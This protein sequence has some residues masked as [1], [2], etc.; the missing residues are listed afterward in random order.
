MPAPNH[1]QV[2]RGGRPRRRAE[3]VGPSADA[4]TSRRPDLEAAIERH[5]QQSGSTRPGLIIACGALVREINA[6][7]DLNDIALFDVRAIPATYHNRPERI[8]G[9][10]DDLL[11]AAGGHY[12]HVFV[13]YAEC[14]TQG[15]LDAVLKRHGVSRLPGAHCYSVFSGAAHFDA[16]ADR[17]PTAFYLTDFLARHFV[18]LVWRGLGLDRHPELLTAYFGNYTKLIYLAQTTDDEALVQ[19]REAALRLGL[20]FEHCPTGYGELERELVAAGR[21]VAFLTD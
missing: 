10:V 5:R 12:A 11:A 16:M 13:A 2:R 21:R 19:A 15:A 6:V 1:K 20:A 4:A 9:A 3:R 7:L 18:A 17:D 14:G 8:A